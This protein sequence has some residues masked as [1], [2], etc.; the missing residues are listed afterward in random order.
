MMQ[1]TVASLRQML[2]ALSENDK[3]V[4]VH[5][6]FAGQHLL[7]AALPEVTHYIRLTGSSM[8]A[9]A[10]EQEFA[11]ALGSS[12]LKATDSLVLD[13]SD[14]ANDEALATFVT[15]TL[16]PRLKKGRIILTGRKVPHALLAHPAA[17]GKVQFLPVSSEQMW[18]DYAAPRPADTHILEVWALGSGRTLIDGH[19][20]DNWEGNLPR[21]LFHYLVDK[22]LATRTEI[23]Q[24]FW[25]ELS[26]KEATNVFHVTKRKVNEVLGIDLTL[27]ES[28]F[29]RISPRIQLSYDVSL[30]N[31]YV[32]QSEIANGAEAHALL[33]QALAFNPSRFLTSLDLPW[34]KARREELAQAYAD[35][36]AALGRNH[37]E[38]GRKAQALTCYQRASA[39]HPQRE[40]IVERVLSLVSDHGDAANG[41]R[42]YERYTAALEG[43]GITP[44]AHLAAL[45]ER[46]R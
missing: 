43:T 28:S 6:N 5:P 31:H 20:I 16:M 18:N 29:Y 36:L 1:T 23:F 46:L 35:A 37:E 2:A 32:Q 9:A 17:S 11:V 26:V 42:V 22:G 13:E 45:A 12:K 41:M 8:N 10:L 38:S 24:T 19:A 3:I 40:D 39:Q 21:A 4:V 30:F 34:V 44:A 33:E 14:R 7:L 27:Y 25:P 15:E